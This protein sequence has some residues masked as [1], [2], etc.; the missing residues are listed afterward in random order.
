MPVTY[1]P[2]PPY[3]TKK[4]LTDSSRVLSLSLYIAVHDPTLTIEEALTNR[5]ARMV[6]INVNGV[7]AINLGLKHREALDMCRRTATN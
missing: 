3:N 7:T 1:K 5:Y 6:F 4:S 2:Y